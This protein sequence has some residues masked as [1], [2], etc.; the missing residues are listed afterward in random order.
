VFKKSVLRR[1]LRLK[2]QGVAGEWKKLHNEELNVSYSPNNIQVMKSR[3]MS[4]EGPVAHMGKRRGAYRVL[5]GKPEGKRP[6]GRSR[7][8]WENN[9]KMDLQEMGWKGMDWIDLAH[10]R[11]VAGSCECG[12]ETSGFIKCEGFLTS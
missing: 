12:N 9:I 5:V 6:L 10:D 11:R 8:R 2:W 7:L 3:R 1:T 4:W